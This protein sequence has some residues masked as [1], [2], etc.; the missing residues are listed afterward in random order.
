[1]TP[2]FTVARVPSG[3]GFAFGTVS[4]PGEPFAV[5]AVLAAPFAAPGA[6]TRFGCEAVVPAQ[7]VKQITVNAAIE[8]PTIF[9]RCPHLPTREGRTDS[10]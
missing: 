4:L 5:L 10:C 6:P 8:N 9:M 3:L 1:M 2:P 7:P